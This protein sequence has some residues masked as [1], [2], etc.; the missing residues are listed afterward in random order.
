[1]SLL[2]PERLYRLLPA[3]H[4]L[5][6]HEAG[7]P[8]RALLGIVERELE[9]VESDTATLYDD[10]FIETCDDWVVPYI[11]DLVRAR[12]IRPVESAG[13][14]VRGYVANTIAYRR[15]KGTALVVEQLA[16]D[17]TGWPARVVEYFQ[18]LLTAQ[19]TNHVRSQ[20]T[21][22][23][24]LRDA[25]LAELCD[26]AF[27]RYAHT[28]EVRRPTTRGGR[29][30]I[31]NLGIFLWRLKSHS[32]GFGKPGDAA[33]DFSSAR[34]SAAGSGVAAGGWWSVHPAGVDAPLFNRPRTEGGIMQ[35]TDEEH[36]PARLRGL[37]LHSEFERV[38]RGLDQPPAKF[39]T[40]EEP[41]LRVFVRLAGST[42]PVEVLPADMHLCVLPPSATGGSPAMLAM[43]LD[44][45]RGR[46]T[47][48]PGFD[49]REVWLHSSLGFSGDS[50]GG[51]YDRSAA[52]ADADR[53]LA[54]DPSRPDATRGFHGASVWQAGVSHLHPAN[55]SVR[56]FPSL[57]TAVDAWNQQPAGSTGVIVLMDSLS[58]F[59]AEASPGLPL[60][61]EI[62]EGSQLLIVAGEWPLDPVPGAPGTFARFAGRF[63]A[64]TVRA[65]HVGGLVVRGAAP[66]SSE[67]PGG[68]FINGLWL[69]GGIAVAAGNLG[70][71]DVAHSTLVPGSGGLD[72]HPNGNSRLALSLRRSI[73]SAIDVPGPV[74]SVRIRDSIVEGDGSSPGFA[75]SVADAMLELEQV[76]A[77]GRVDARS[78]SASGCIFRDS[79]RAERRQT[80][81][82]RFSYVP[83][84]SVVP[85]RYRCQPDREVAARVEAR[86]REAAAEGR[87]ASADEL[88]GIR[89]EVRATVRPQFVSTRYGDPG[90]AQIEMH[91]AEQIRT[92]A[93]SGAE[94]GAFE[95]LK[96]AQR[97]ANLRDAL[98]EYVRFGLD[99]C[100]AFV[101]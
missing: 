34:R 47:F 94:M 60:A 78:I 38:R 19:H 59:D 80:G 50:G 20:P 26:G 53:E 9:R 10:W 71:L 37:A 101:N 89:A 23:P 33:A 32:V 65:H 15:R 79:V 98:E 91:T 92:G 96:Q 66:S 48:T 29:H 31:P 22:A 63:S 93:E 51:P 85:R 87:T 99:A 81:C 21:A 7:E 57:R 68:C 1:M 6:D 8:L 82:V 46:V 56:M 4:R 17:V 35:R 52:V 45:Q 40:A 27:D 24:S 90:Y 69:E 58:D 43:A 54:V 3:F 16:R 14:S 36:V 5:R 64:T 55:G 30:N 62:G 41:V 83:P 73:S 13:V 67:N 84:G 61:I 39:M 72:V 100:I 86:Q 12:P 70:R 77:L 75:L 2:T 28:L 49:V 18:T 97:E 11:G 25:A 42:R 74:A 88:D 44:P 76:T 95:F